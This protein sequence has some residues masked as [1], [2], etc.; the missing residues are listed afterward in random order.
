VTGRPLVRM[1]H[2]HAPLRKMQI[3]IPFSES[4]P[5]VISFCAPTSG[6]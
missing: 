6:S 5:D 4:L 3:Q 2:N 1:K